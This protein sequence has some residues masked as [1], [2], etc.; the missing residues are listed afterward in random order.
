MESEKLQEIAERYYELVWSHYM[1]QVSCITREDY[2][3][4]Q[5][6]VPGYINETYNEHM[7]RLTQGIPNDV[8]VMVGHIRTFLA[9]YVEFQDPRYA[10]GMEKMGENLRKDKELFKMKALKILKEGYLEQ[11]SG[12]RKAEELDQH[13]PLFETYIGP[14]H[15]IIPTY[16]NP[17][18]TCLYSLLF[19][20]FGLFQA[21]DIDQSTPSGQ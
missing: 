4:M 7:A 3:R 1:F 2:D 8:N 21:Q 19:S 6:V 16:C 5:Q 15:F 11:E 14:A 17:M 20:L 13:P 12:A 10:D 18:M 9:K